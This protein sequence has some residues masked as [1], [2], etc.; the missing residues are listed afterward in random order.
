MKSAKILAP[1]SELPLRVSTPRCPYCHDEVTPQSSKRAC[2]TCMTW[3]HA[4]CWDEHGACAACQGALDATDPALGDAAEHPPAPSAPAPLSRWRALG[5]LLLGYLAYGIAVVLAAAVVARGSNSSV[6]ALVIT[7]FGVVFAYPL[8]RWAHLR[9]PLREPVYGAP[10]QGWVIA[11]TLVQSVLIALIALGLR[12]AG[13]P[14]DSNLG[15]LFLVTCVLLPWAEELFARGWAY[16][17]A[18]RAFGGV[19]AALL[20]ALI[21]S[22]LELDPRMM[23]FYFVSALFATL[24]YEQTGR[25]SAAFALRVAGGLACLA[26]YAR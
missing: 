18:K 6:G 17:V 9:M 26:F 11:L 4:E 7:L 22:L 20:V 10:F 12:D 2:A 3:Q 1:A 21:G 25:I 8:Y 14:P 15:Q 13:V 16:P 23:G 24:A 19:G 5:I